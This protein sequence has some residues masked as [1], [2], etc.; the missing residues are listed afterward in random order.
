MS[1]TALPITD[2]DFIASFLGPSVVREAFIIRYVTVSVYIT[3]L[4]EHLASLPEE[5]EFIWKAP[6]NLA[7]ICFLLY[8]Y[9]S[10]A[11]LT[12]FTYAMANLSGALHP[13]LFVFLH[14]YLPS[15]RF[16]IF[17]HSCKHAIGGLAALAVFSMGVGDALVMLRVSV[18]WG[19]QRIVLAILFLSF[20]FTYSTAVVCVVLGAVIVVSNTIV[21]PIVNLCVPLIKPYTLLGVWIPGLIFD[22]LVLTMTSWNACARPRTQET[23]LTQALYRDGIAFFLILAGLRA[24]NFFMTIFSS[25]YLVGVCI[26]WPLSVITFSRFVFH[27][28]H[29]EKGQALLDINAGSQETIGVV[30]ADEG[31]SVQSLPLPP[32]SHG[33]KHTWEGLDAQSHCR[34]STAAGSDGISRR[35]DSIE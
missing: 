27:L 22:T 14:L 21:I 9:S 29:L 31:R 25:L 8:R 4:L 33:H 34:T 3:F 23:A 24:L 18:L 16:H 5:V 7:R 28:Q 30:R 20:F 11:G 13:N 26:T 1:T 15:E 35:K 2:Q 32:C 6:W 12:I 17:D 19:R 10:V